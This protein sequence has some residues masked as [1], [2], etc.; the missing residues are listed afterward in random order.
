VPAASGS[1]DLGTVR[2]ENT[3]GRFIPSA[4]YAD[5]YNM[6]MNIAQHQFPTRCSSKGN[7]G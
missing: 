4:E 3:S 5:H 2:N 6:G 1:I 7:I